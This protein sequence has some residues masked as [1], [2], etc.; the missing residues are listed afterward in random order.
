M[1]VNIEG[2]WDAV[3][4]D[5]MQQMQAPP[6]PQM[7]VIPQVTPQQMGIPVGKP[8]VG[9]GSNSL[10][11]FF[12]SIPKP[13]INPDTG[14]SM[15]MQPQRTPGTV[16]MR[17]NQID[18]RGMS[19]DQVKGLVSNVVNLNDL[20]MQ[21]Q[22]DP[23]EQAKMQFELAKFNQ[24]VKEWQAKQAKPEEDKVEYADYVDKNTGS[25]VR[26]P[27]NQA[28]IDPNLMPTSLYDNYMAQQAKEEVDTQ[29]QMAEKQD[30]LNTL[31][32]V[33]DSVLEQGYYTGKKGVV[34]LDPESPEM[35][36]FVK[37]YN[38]TSDT[39]EYVYEDIPLSQYMAEHP[40][41]PKWLAEKT[42]K[43]FGNNKGWVLKP[44]QGSNMVVEQPAMPT[45]ASSVG[46]TQ[47]QAQ[48]QAPPAAIEYLRQNPQFKEAFKAKYGYIPEGI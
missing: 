14:S 20:A 22:V 46:P 2:L 21:H 27:K 9:G 10:A 33:I 7:Q 5:P 40:M 12:Q 26:V 32:T 28:E 35:K 39:D 42:S 34:E 18:L 29:K 47:A 19:P 41:I 13:W 15:P 25:V 1:P 31:R 8:L 44:K 23:F 4:M 36:G 6:Q 45:A 3:G 48:G 11:N 30:K 38:D 16:Q 43:L 37:A 17:G 24:Q